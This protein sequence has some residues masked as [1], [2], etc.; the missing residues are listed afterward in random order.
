MTA[1]HWLEKR[2]EETR[3]AV[4]IHENALEL[5]KARYEAFAEMWR[6][7]PKE[8]M[9]IQIAGDEPAEEQ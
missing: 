1:R 4:R 6:N 8:Q 5:A 7:L 3:N 9:E 2:I